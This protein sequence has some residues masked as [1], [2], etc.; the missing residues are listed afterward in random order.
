MVFHRNPDAM[1]GELAARLGESKP[2]G[3]L[4]IVRQ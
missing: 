2:T 1:W 4:A 3:A